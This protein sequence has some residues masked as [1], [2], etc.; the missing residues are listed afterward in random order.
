MNKSPAQIDGDEVV[1][2]VGAGILLGEEAGGVALIEG[3][4]GG[5]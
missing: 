4:D 1:V 3:M 5:W 2:D